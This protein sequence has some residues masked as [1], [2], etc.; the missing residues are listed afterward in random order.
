MSDPTDE[1]AAT[2]RARRRWTSRLV[3]LATC[4]GVA[5]AIASAHAESASGSI[6]PETGHGY[7]MALQALTG[8]QG[9]DLTVEVTPLPGHPV[10]ESIKKLQLKIYDAG[11]KLDDVRNLND[12]PA[13]GGR[14]TIGLGTLGRGLRIGVHALVQTGRPS[15]THVLQGETLTKLRPDLVVAT[16]DA[17]PQTL[18]TR[19]IDVRAEIAEL[20]GDTA[21]TGRATLMWGPTPLAGPTPIDVPAGGRLSV[22]FPAVELTTLP[23][24]SSSPSW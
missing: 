20:N 12:V 1:S 16:V 23:R 13:P 21:A 5:A 17:P 22:T 14:A 24:R 6:R 4:A 18:T 3:V 10:P 19:P 9:A 15:R 2:A 7:T 8:P 11:G